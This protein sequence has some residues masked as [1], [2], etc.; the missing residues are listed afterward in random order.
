MERI[1]V[2]ARRAGKTAGVASRILAVAMVVVVALVLLTAV[3]SAIQTS[4]A[5]P[6][7]RTTLTAVAAPTEL[8]YFP[9]RPY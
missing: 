4:I 6:V 1:S 9:G 3:Y 8:P 5:G 2:S 7:D